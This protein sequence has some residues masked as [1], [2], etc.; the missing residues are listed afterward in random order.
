MGDYYRAGIDVAI[1]SAKALE[2]SKQINAAL[3]AIERAAKAAGKTLDNAFAFKG[4]RGAIAGLKDYRAEVERLTKSA[5]GLDRA[6]SRAATTRRTIPGA[7][8]AVSAAA[9]LASASN[10]A[11]GREA[12]AAVP[13]AAVAA[14]TR[15]VS[16]LETALVTAGARSARAFDHVFD[17]ISSIGTLLTGGAFAIGLRSV[18]DAEV[19]FRSTQTAL[20]AAT[21]SAREGASAWGFI[22]SEADRLGVSIR[23]L[24]PEY[25]KLAASTRNTSLEGEGTRA[26]FT[27]V[28]EA[29]LVLGLSADQTSNAFRAFS[30]IAS[31]GTVQAEEIRGQLGDVLPGAF[32]LL[33]EGLGV[34]QVQLNKLLQKGLIPADVGINALVRSMNNAFG[35]AVPAAIGSARAEFSR[36]SNS[37][38]DFQRQ[39]ANAGVLDA[40]IAQVKS[41]REELGKRETVE[42]AKELADNLTRLAA[43]GATGIRG[44]VAEFLKLPT[45]VQEAGIVGALLFGTRGVFAIVALLGP[46]RIIR[47]EI[48]LLTGAWEGKI[49]FLDAVFTGINGERGNAT[50]KRLREMNE[51]IERAT[52]SEGVGAGARITR[53]ADIDRMLAAPKVAGFNRGALTSERDKLT[54]ERAG[55]KGSVQREKAAAMEALRAGGIAT[56][57]SALSGQQDPLFPSSVGLFDGLM[58]KPKPTLDTTGGADKAAA[59]AAKRRAEAIADAEF[60]VAS[61]RKL[62]AAQ[63]ESEAA[64]QRVAN[65]IEVEARAR[66]AG[67]D[68]K[69][70]EGHRFS[71]LTAEALRL[72]DATDRLKA[73]QG[74]VADAMDNSTEHTSG[75]LAAVQ[76]L[77]ANIETTGGTVEDF[78]RG[79]ERLA[80]ADSALS[81]VRE[82]ANG[83]NE[84]Y[85]R[86]VQAIEAAA[87]AGIGT[88][89]EWSKALRRLAEDRGLDTIAT[90]EQARAR[91]RSISIARRSPGLARGFE[92]FRQSI[93]DEVE[94][95][96]RLGEEIPRTISDGLTAAFVR[97]AKAAEAFKDT[98]L[99]IQEA[100]A[101][102]FVEK[103]IT[104][105]LLGFVD[106]TFFGGGKAGA[107]GS[108]LKNL[109]AGV[110]PV[111]VTNL[112]TVTDAFVEST[113][114]T[115]DSLD[116][117][118]E[119]TQ[120]GL[121]GL[122]QDFSGYIT[123]LGSVLAGALGP[124]I[125]GLG[126]AAAGAKGGGALGKIQLGLGIITAVGGAFS[127]ISGAGSK[128]AAFFNGGGA[129]SPGLTSINTTRGMI[130]T[131]V[132]HGGG[133]VSMLSR[134]HRAPMGAFSM[135]H[136]FH[137]GGF[138]GLAP[139]EVPIIAR[140]GEAVVP[141]AN[142][143]IPVD[144]RGS[145]GGGSRVNVFVSNAP[146]E[147]SPS[148]RSQ[149]GADGSVD[150]FIDFERRIAERLSSGA[151]PLARAIPRSF[152]APRRPETR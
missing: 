29:A 16:R 128:L 91:E 17:R 7:G 138:P 118:S 82:D 21:G 119:A 62:L 70:A 132:A 108:A 116:K 135:A 139:G 42:G 142:G 121:S 94:A 109:P 111:Y 9:A 102:H 123:G 52:K 23:D 54:A 140:R 95:M 66:S 38:F 100:V 27:A 25:A 40:V 37:I 8:A 55:L 14:A 24:S 86:S 65:A 151:G 48:E 87:R 124:I 148:V 134:T 149:Q 43:D 72:S 126:L 69:S 32:R 4:S 18:V 41:L 107:G 79:L 78:R 13:A 146:A 53:L 88:D 20:A 115:S 141:L 137:A 144:V 113:K 34:T 125:G 36:F 51:E 75:Y 2:G 120:T 77:A 67:I 112:P 35:P 30:Q 101:R 93:G 97:P 33:A 28:S 47:A 59:T 103:T 136:R 81:Q 57:V 63:R 22:A 80:N 92:T 84:R 64:Y 99:G 15:Q 110:S 60:E 68:L 129:Q 96:Q 130:G 61:T 143:S 6:L 19:S 133:L 74:A 76:I 147:S 39:L 12:A 145:G 150:V 3:D 98:L 131:G 58:P 26:V 1:E 117:L 11:I 83:P 71:A 105:P 122:S 85:L 127:S 44:I 10:T 31:K 152:N 45:A 73:V 5:A 106:E 49:P 46:I 104:K 50:L 56:T 114:S 90:E 89:Q